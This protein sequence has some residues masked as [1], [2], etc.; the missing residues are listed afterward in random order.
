MLHTTL[1][2]VAIYEMQMTKVEGNFNIN[3]EVSKVNKPNLIFFQP[4]ATKIQCYFHLKG[5]QMNDKDEKTELRIHVIVGASEYARTKINQNI[6]IGNRVEPVEE[7]TA[8]G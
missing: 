5:V 2:H 3:T 7:Y 8:F 1:S 6:R 4:L